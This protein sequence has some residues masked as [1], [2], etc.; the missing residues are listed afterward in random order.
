MDKE[1]KD[2]LYNLLMTPS[3]TGSEQQIQKLIRERMVNY[4]EEIRTDLHGN[5]I[6]ALNTKAKRRVM[7]AGHCDQIALM[8]R[9]ISP[10]G[11][12]YV[13]ALGGIDITVLFGSRVT[14]VTK[15]GNINGV[16]GKKPIHLIKREDRELVSKLEKVWVD[17]GAKDEKSAREF[18]ELGDPIVFKPEVSYLND[19]LIVA[20]GLD[21]RVG[22]FTVMEVMKLCHKK[23]LNVGLY[24]V[25]TVQEEIGLRG[26]HTS[27]YSVQP[28]VGIAVDVTFSTD[29]PGSEG[30]QA[31]PIK[32]GSGPVIIR[33]PNINSEVEA[34]M[35]KIAKKNKINTQVA[36]TSRPLGN[37]ANAIQLSRAGVAT[38]SL[39]IPSRYMHTQ[40]EVCSLQDLN[41]SIKLLSNFV[42][43]ITPEDDF[44][45]KVALIE[46]GH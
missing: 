2:F 22:V 23:K 41:D 14:V 21:D 1:S 44:I 26:A 32:L 45:P 34:S 24:C 8:V 35:F 12:L 33:G 4:A 42:Q 46:Q 11:Y 38:G 15:K 28:E 31:P 29:N 40:V 6:V 7:L 37:D 30:S 18:V 5:L 10:D 3:P 20:P 27:A 25:S 13:S 43:S 36:I 16:I 9:Y 39:G 17:I 19:D